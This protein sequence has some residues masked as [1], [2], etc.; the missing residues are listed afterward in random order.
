MIFSDYFFPGQSFSRTPPQVQRLEEG[1]LL[2]TEH[3][4]DPQ[5]HGQA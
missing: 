4:D 3:P 1:P 5:P 2:L